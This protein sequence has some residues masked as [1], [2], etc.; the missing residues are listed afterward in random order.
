[1]RKHQVL[2]AQLVERVTV[3]HEVVGSKPTG[4]EF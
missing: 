2:I 1:M 4:N 3:N